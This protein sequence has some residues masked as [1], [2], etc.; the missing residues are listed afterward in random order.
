MISVL[1][2]HSNS[3]H[4]YFGNF[5]KIDTRN[6]F[7]QGRRDKNTIVGHVYGVNCFHSYKAQ[8]FG[9]KFGR[10]YNYGGGFTYHGR[11]FSGGLLGKKG[12]FGQ[13]FGARVSTNGR[14]TIYLASGVVGV[15]GTLV[16]FSFHGGTRVI[17]TRYVTR[18]TRV[19]SVHAHTT[20]Q[21]NGRVR[22][23]FYA[24]FRVLRVLFKGVER[25][26]QGV[27]RVGTFI[28][29]CQPAIRG[30]T[31]GVVVFGNLGL[32]EGRTIVGRGGHT[33]FGVAKGPLV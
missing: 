3:G 26:G 25:H 7:A 21:D 27:K 4:R 19:G 10:L 6:N 23:R 24:R 29:Y 15:V 8:V 20:G 12:F 16:V 14:G 9:R 2:Y 30:D 5:R 32:G 22:T 18:V 33:L 11:F 1:L 17:P 13:S 28:V 31:S